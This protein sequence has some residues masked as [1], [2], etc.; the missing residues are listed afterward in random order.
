MTKTGYHE[1]HD[2]QK[3]GEELGDK[4]KGLRESKSLS[5]YRL[6]QMANIPQSSI[7]RL[8][9]GH[10]TGVSSRTLNRIAD[11]L[12]TTIDYLLTESGTAQSA[13]TNANRWMTILR[14]VLSSSDSQMII[15][16][17]ET[18]VLAS[19]IDDIADGILL[20]SYLSDKSYSALNSSLSDNTNSQVRLENREGKDFVMDIKPVYMA[21]D[22]KNVDTQRVTAYI[23]T[24]VN[25]SHTRLDTS[26]NYEALVEAIQ[27]D[28]DLNAYRKTVAEHLLSLSEI[29]TIAFIFEKDTNNENAFLISDVYKRNGSKVV[30]K[31]FTFLDMQSGATLTDPKA[32][33]AVLST[34]RNQITNNDEYIAVSNRN[35]NETL[36]CILIK[37]SDIPK[38]MEA[39]YESEAYIDFSNFL[40]EK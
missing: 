30:V 11:A 6:S 32:V 12:N 26:A 28:D 21:E 10:K 17:S 5:Q 34:A 40:L 1:E 8:E 38:T 20:S 9:S 35:M 31:S 23:C 37:S 4:I 2:G 19:S 15:L 3:H 39:L 22:P 14:K 29:N 25:N 13:G 7:S 36:P 33:M 16:N 27:V 18:E 24:V